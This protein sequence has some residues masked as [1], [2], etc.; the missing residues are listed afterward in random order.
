MCF[1]STSIEIDKIS[2]KNFGAT[3]GQNTLKAFK[4]KAF[5]A[6]SIGFEFRTDLSI[7]DNLCIIFL[8]TVMGQGSKSLLNKGIERD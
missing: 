5:S 1:E 2:V 4:I 8:G 6:S 3:M 7:D